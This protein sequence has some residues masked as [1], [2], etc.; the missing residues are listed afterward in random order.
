M[1][2]R[3]V[4]MK[5]GGIEQI[6]SPSQV[7]LDPATP[8]VA[9]FVGKTNL[10]PAEA[11]SARS[12]QVGAQRFECDFE[13]SEFKGTRGLR[14]FFR[15]E[16]VIVRGVNGSTPNSASAVVEKIEFLGAYSRLAFRVDGIEQLL[17]ADLSGN[18]MAEFTPKPGDRFRV[19]LPPERLRL[20]EA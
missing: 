18:D 3:I 4:V 19:A 10:L 12:I 5:E 11:S 9:D 7:Y 8:F 13:W 6:G 1:A 2:D 14:L 17:F 15:P 16:D 20:F